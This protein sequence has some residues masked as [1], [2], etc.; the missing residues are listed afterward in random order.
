MARLGTMRFV[1]LPFRDG[2]AQ[3]AMRLPISARTAALM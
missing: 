2:V 3:P 1:T